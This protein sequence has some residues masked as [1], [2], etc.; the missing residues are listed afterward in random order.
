MFNEKKSIGE[1]TCFINLLLHFCNQIGDSIIVIL[2]TRHRLT[3]DTTM[4][5]IILS[6]SC[7]QP[8]CRP[9]QHALIVLYNHGKWVCIFLDGS[10]NVT[11]RGYSQSKMEM[12]WVDR[13]IWIMWKLIVSLWCHLNKWQIHRERHELQCN[14]SCFLELEGLLMGS[15]VNYCHLPGHTA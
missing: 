2:A 12:G 1:L 3:S 9:H 14:N 13:F 5:G 11:Q 8:A 6:N 10:G 7:S 4:A 15:Q